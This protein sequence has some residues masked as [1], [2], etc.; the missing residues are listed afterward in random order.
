MQ[1]CFGA[2]LK[3]KQVW[4]KTDE[5]K[6]Y[7]SFSNNSLSDT[8]TWAAASK[9][10]PSNMRKKRILRSSCACARYYPGLVSLLTYNV[11]SNHSVCGHGRPW[12]DCADAQADLGLCCPHAPEDTLV[13]CTA[14]I[15]SY[16]ENLQDRYIDLDQWKRFH[17][18]TNLNAYIQAQDQPVK[19]NILI[20]AFVVRRYIPQYHRILLP[21]TSENIPSYVCVWTA[22]SE[23]VLHVCT[24]SEYSDQT[25]HSR[26]L[27]RIFTGHIL[28]RQK[29]PNFFKRT[30]ITLLRLGGYAGWS[31]SLLAAHVRKNGFSRDVAVPRNPVSRKRWPDTCTI[32]WLLGLVWDFALRIYQKH[33][34][35]FR[36]LHVPLPMGSLIFCLQTM[37]KLQSN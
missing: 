7:N 1:N 5:C 4:H 22:T 15:L 13:H 31:E 30:T 32:A 36:Y 11:V 14:R 18:V 20:I 25:A 37:C 26:S 29:M 28:K 19:P 27:I 9:T 10:V 8:C 24:L 12:S 21:A 35:A 2:P 17:D 6:R 34:F 23:N 33:L 16:D 3:L